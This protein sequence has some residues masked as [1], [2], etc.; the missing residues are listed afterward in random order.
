MSESEIFILSTRYS[1]ADDSGVMVDVVDGM[2]VD[3][4]VVDGMVVDG[5]VV[6]RL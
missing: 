1:S 5:M 4:M 2:V 6:I 3:G